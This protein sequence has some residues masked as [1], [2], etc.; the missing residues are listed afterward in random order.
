MLEHYAYIPQY[1]TKLKQIKKQEWL[2]LTCGIF[3]SDHFQIQRFLE[4]SYQF[5]PQRLQH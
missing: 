4:I 5:E 1:D 3:I 2:W